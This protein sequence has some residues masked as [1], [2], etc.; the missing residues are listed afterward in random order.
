MQE[1]SLYYGVLQEGM[2]NPKTIQEKVDDV[3]WKYKE[4]L[5]DKEYKFWKSYN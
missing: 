2:Y 4:V 3:I 1:A 5:T